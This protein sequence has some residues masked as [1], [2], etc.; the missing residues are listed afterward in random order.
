[1]GIHLTAHYCQ[2]TVL[3]CGVV[4]PAAPVGYTKLHSG[5]KSREQV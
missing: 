2:N 1:M 5:M 4:M 3:H